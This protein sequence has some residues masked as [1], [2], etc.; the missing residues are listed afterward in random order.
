M[1]FG[2][3]D[4]GATEQGLGLCSPGELSSYSSS[5][6]STTSG[7]TGGGDVNELSD[8]KQ[9][10]LIRLTLPANYTWNSVQVSSLDNNGGSPFEHG[11]LWAGNAATPTGLAGSLTNET[12]ICTFIAGSP[13]TAANG[14][15][16]LSGANGNSPTFSVAG[17]SAGATYLFF[18]AYDWTNTS[19]KNNDYLV[20]AASVTRTPEPGTLSLLGIGIAGIFGRLRRKRA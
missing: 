20:K 17:G 7:K 4:G 19:N 9:G 14:C 8:E 13:V 11:I 16:I 3:N 10:E 1:L 6:Y 2:R 15:T 12:K 18:E 5:C